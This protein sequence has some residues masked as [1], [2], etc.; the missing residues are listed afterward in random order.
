[1]SIDFQSH[2][3]SQS[4]SKRRG[5]VARFVVSC[6]LSLR[7]LNLAFVIAATSSSNV[8]DSIAVA[9]LESAIASVTFAAFMRIIAVEDF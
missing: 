7:S 1:M 8:A 9:V 5:L 6:D 3:H 4:H 2:S